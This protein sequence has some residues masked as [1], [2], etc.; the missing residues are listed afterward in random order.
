MPSENYSF[1]TISRITEFNQFTYYFMIQIL[2]DLIF[3]NVAFVMYFEIML[4]STKFWD[5][6]QF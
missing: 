3:Q 1:L 5:Q 6:K 4:K 2:S